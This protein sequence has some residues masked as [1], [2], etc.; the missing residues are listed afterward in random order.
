MAVTMRARGEIPKPGSISFDDRVT[1]KVPHEW[2]YGSTPRTAGLRDGLHWK[3]PIV[4]EWLNIAMGL[5]K[6]HLPPGP[7]R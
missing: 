1:K 7:A 5:G 3:A 6:L 4:K 2:G